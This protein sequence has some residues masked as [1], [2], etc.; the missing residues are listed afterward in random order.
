M[1]LTRMV[2]LDVTVHTTGT[3]GGTR[4]QARVSGSEKI[5]NESTM[6]S[7]AHRGMHTQ[8]WLMRFMAVW[9]IK[10]KSRFGC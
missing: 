1:S 10:Q 3:A 6:R 8:R 5:Q 7:L 4:R 9:D 2:E